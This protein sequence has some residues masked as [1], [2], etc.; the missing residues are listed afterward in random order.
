[1]M[2]SFETRKETLRGEREVWKELESN[3]AHVT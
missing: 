1:M 3:E 2:L